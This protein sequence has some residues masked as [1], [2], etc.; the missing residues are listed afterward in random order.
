MCYYT[1]YN[2][3]C[4]PIVLRIQY[5]PKQCVRLFYTYNLQSEVNGVGTDSRQVLSKDHKKY[6][7][8]SKNMHKYTHRKCKTQESS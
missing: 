5:V 2:Y 8:V 3:K 6:A 7:N 4:V 1:Q